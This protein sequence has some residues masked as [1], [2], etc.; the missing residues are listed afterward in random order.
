MSD[1]RSQRSAVTAEYFAAQQRPSFQ[2]NATLTMKIKLSTVT[3]AALLFAG[4]PLA[5]SSAYIGISVGFAP[6]VIPIYEQPYCPGPGYIW[7]PGYWA[8]NGFDY[9]W[10]PGYWA[11]PPRIGF[12]WTPGYWGYSG[13][14][15]AFYDGYWGSR[16]G[17]YGGIN[18]GYGYFGRGYY[19]GE[20]VGSTFRYNTAVTRVNTTVIKNTYVNNNYLKTT[21]TRTSFNGPGGVTATATAEE[22]AAA[23]AEHVAPTSEQRAR[24]EAAKKDP[25]LLAKNNK[26]KP[27]EDAVQAFNRTHG[28][29]AGGGKAKGE[30][31]SEGH[32][33]S[34]FGLKQGDATTRTK[35]SQNNAY[36]KAKSAEAQTSHRTT[37]AARTEKLTTPRAHKAVDMKSNRHVTDAA[38]AHRTAQRPQIMSRRPQATQIRRQGKPATTAHAKGQ[39]AQPDGKKKKKPANE[40]PGRRR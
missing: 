14:R 18:Y 21:T 34:A 33:N 7:A 38:T 12:Y 5:S 11:Y 19:G 28:V 2:P 30:T 39:D 22:Q 31:A 32:G 25:A 23:K 6:P 8:W 29:K 24:V 1:V 27:K 15:Y 17:Y 16:V 20:W 9:Y 4:L 37:K 3:L 26:G 40:A 35:G 36:G 10:V 13:G